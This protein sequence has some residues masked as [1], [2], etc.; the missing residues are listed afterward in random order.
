MRSPVMCERCGVFHQRGGTRTCKAH[1]RDGKPCTQFPVGG[2]F[3]TVCKMHGGM[4]RAYRGKVER[5][6]EMVTVERRLLRIL[7]QHRERR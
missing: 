3:G 4:T 7:R 6:R 2:E 1:R 5:R